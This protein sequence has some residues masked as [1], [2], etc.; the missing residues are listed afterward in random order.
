MAQKILVVEDESSIRGIIKDYLENAG[1]M[2]LE[3]Q[4]GKEALELIEKENFNLALLDVMLPYVD[5]WTLCRR[6]KQNGPI[7]VIFLTAR[8]E[9]YDEV[10]GFEIGADDYIKKPFSPAVL[11]M[12][13]NRLLDKQQEIMPCRGN[14]VK[15]VIE[16]DTEAMKVKVEGKEINLTHKEFQIL[17]YLAE[18]E[19][20]VLSREN[21]LNEVWGYDY[22]GDERVVDNHIKKIRKA[23]GEY[24]YIIRTVF[25]AGYIFEVE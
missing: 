23:L 17:S 8:T 7:P 2:V 10:M 22:I 21:I 19:G 4:N 15:S 12:R 25:G 1:F 24:A 13:V 14:I 20:R 3:A 6:I 9:E 5:G 16:I 18:N 11:L